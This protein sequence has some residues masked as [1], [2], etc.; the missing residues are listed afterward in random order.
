M[1]AKLRRCERKQRWR[2]E[3]GFIIR[4]GDQETDALIADLGEGGAA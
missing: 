2:K 3:H 4:M 1:V